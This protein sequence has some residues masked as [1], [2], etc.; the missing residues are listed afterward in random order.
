MRN[1][2]LKALSSLPATLDATYARILESIEDATC[3]ELA[4][5]CLIW[6]G[7]SMVPLTV[8]ELA[9]AAVLDRRPFDPETRLFDPRYV[10]ELLGSLV[11][12]SDY[13]GTDLVA[14]AH[15]SVQ[16]YLTSPRIQ[17]TSVAHFAMN[18]PDAHSLLAESCLWYLDFRSQSSTES[19][20]L[21]EEVKAAYPLLF[22]VG[23]FYVQHLRLA[24]V[25]SQQRTNP[26]ISRLFPSNTVTRIPPQALGLGLFS[27]WYRSR[28]VLHMFAELGIASVVLLQLERG[29][30]VNSRDGLG[31]TA[32]IAAVNSKSEAL[33]RL[34][35]ERG[36]DVAAHDTSG[37][38]A[39]HEVF[40][41]FNPVEQ[42]TGYAVAILRLLT[43]YEARANAQTSAHTASESKPISLISRRNVSWETPIHI[44]SD[45]I[46][47]A[48]T[49]A[50]EWMLS[51]GASVTAGNFWGKTPLHLAASRLI[52]SSTHI[53]LMLETADIMARTDDGETVL[54]FAE[55]TRTTEELQRFD[56]TV[57]ELLRERTQ[58]VIE[59]GKAEERDRAQKERRKEEIGRLMEEWPRNPRIVEVGEYGYEL[60]KDFNPGGRLYKPLVE[61]R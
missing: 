9:E 30:D 59:S 40:H 58:L 33:V 29:T 27:S 57:L 37:F 12:V 26:V 4:H 43:E 53:A 22:Y 32:L 49:A 10:I 7:Y 47:I 50:L 60:W 24:P 61:N 45:L 39:M 19:R 51:H 6:L 46:P 44:F 52:F 15:F 16:E 14:L 56:P 5:R 55:K 41:S 13:E 23:R 42:Q 54:Q 3:Q 21:A 25:Q 1:A 34:L 36:A 35:L 28:S 31:Q 2:I 8:E 11:T 18:E 17:R 38:T 48:D 20:L